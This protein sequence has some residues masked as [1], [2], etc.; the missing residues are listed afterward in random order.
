MRP[1][2]RRP[3]KRAP[4]AKPADDEQ[5]VATFLDGQLRENLDPRLILHAHLV[6][7]EEEGPRAFESCQHGMIGR[8]D[9]LG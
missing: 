8:A 3:G 1:D 2:V 7:A 4:A 6:G 9:D 5:R